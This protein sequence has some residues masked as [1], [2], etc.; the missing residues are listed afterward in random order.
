MATEMGAHTYV[1]IRP[2]P[3]APLDQIPRKYHDGWWIETPT[4]ASHSQF[5]SSPRDAVYVA[6]PADPPDY[7][8]RADG[9]V[10]QVWWLRPAD[11]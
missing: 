9:V 11:D 6:K 7:E 5:N 10:A 4:N 3:D 1:C 2:H 8:M